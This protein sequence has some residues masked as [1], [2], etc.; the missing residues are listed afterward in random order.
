MG[1]AHSFASRPSS[2]CSSFAISAPSHLRPFGRIARARSAPEVGGSSICGSHTGITLNPPSLLHQ[3]LRSGFC[4]LPPAQ[5]C[6][7]LCGSGAKV[8]FAS[9]K[10]QK[11]ICNICSFATFAP[12]PPFFFFAFALCPPPPPHLCSRLAL[13]PAM[14]ALCSTMRT[15]R[16]LASAVTAAPS[17]QTAAARASAGRAPWLTLATCLSLHV[18]RSERMRLCVARV[19]MACPNLSTLRQ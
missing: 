16:S 13:L 12:H 2:F 18:M 3:S 10:M 5:A 1:E 17:Y 14:R 9:R 11:I 8:C 6:Q 19:A 15:K 4:L 7:E